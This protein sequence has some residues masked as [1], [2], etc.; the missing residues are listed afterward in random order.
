HLDRGGLREMYDVLIFPDGAIPGRGGMGPGGVRPKGGFGQPEPRD[1]PEEFRGLP[2][3][4]TAEV[5]IPHLKEFLKEGGT[6][7]TVGSSTG[8]ASHLGLPVADH[9]AV[10]GDDGKERPLGRDK[11]YVPGSVLR[12]R[13]DP[14]S[15]L[16]W[17]L[18][19]EA[20][21]MFSA[22]PTFR[23]PGDAAAKGVRRVAWFDGKTPLRSGWAWGQERLEGG[24]AV[25]E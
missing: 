8:L 10:K 23:L 21:V 4:V 15:P 20:D 14:A 11:F 3:A 9:L 7:I 13:V 24:A 16:A 5:T 18:C 17:G 1:L 19:E 6:I 22:S 2:G 12:V 25:V